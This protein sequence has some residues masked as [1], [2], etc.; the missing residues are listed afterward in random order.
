MGKNVHISTEMNDERY[1]QDEQRAPEHVI[2]G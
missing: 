1:W 2:Q